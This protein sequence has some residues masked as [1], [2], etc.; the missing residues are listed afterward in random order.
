[1]TDFSQFT[2]PSAEW[3]ALEP[4][5]PSQPER[6]VKDLKKMVNSV[7]ENAAGQIMINE[8]ENIGC[9]GIPRFMSPL[10]HQTASRFCLSSPNPRL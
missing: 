2:G 4:T 5:L 9:I 8:G 7:R 10:T 6:S 3:L 1:M